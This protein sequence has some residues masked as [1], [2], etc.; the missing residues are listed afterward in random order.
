M[1]NQA[2]PRTQTRARPRQ[3]RG[4][5]PVGVMAELPPVEAAAIQYLRLWFSGNKDKIWR[6]F[7]NQLDQKSAKKAMALLE[8]LMS[9]VQLHAR[10]PLMRHSDHCECFGGDEC[11]FAHFVGAASSGENHDAMTFGLHLFDADYAEN[12]MKSASDCGLMFL[13]MAGLQ[14]PP[15]ARYQAARSKNPPHTPTHPMPKTRQ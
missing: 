6:D 10:R 9:A 14:L 1:S 4:G 2:R 8:D 7:H 3:S 11:A 5:A 15:L 13:N 12:I